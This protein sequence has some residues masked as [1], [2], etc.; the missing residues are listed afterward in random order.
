MLLPQVTTQ[1]VTLVS[2]LNDLRV[3]SQEGAGQL[4]TDS[5]MHRWPVFMAVMSTHLRS[6]GQAGLQVAPESKS[7]VSKLQPRGQISPVPFQSERFVGVQPGPWIPT[8]PAA[9]STLLAQ[10]SGSNRNLTTHQV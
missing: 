7:G 9:A 10:R 2:R 6:R 5:W 4:S 1:K 3:R 8:P